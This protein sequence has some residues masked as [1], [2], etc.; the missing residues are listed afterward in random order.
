MVDKDVEE[1]IF[2][3]IDNQAESINELRGQVTTLIA[4]LKIEQKY[5][6]EKMQE[7]EKRLDCIT[8]H[9]NK[10]RMYLFA[11][12]IVVMAL[13]FLGKAAFWVYENAGPIVEILMDKNK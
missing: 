8:Q 9:L 2:N 11:G 6:T 12:S 3:K 4:T 1:K 5:L 13:A 7:T 10:F